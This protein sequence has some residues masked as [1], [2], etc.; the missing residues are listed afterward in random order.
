MARVR[1]KVEMRRQII[2]E[3]SSSGLGSKKFCESRGISYSTFCYWQKVERR[4]VAPISPAV[5]LFEPLRSASVN[6]SD[7]NVH[8]SCGAILQIS[9]SVP[10]SEIVSVLGSISR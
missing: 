5:I 4:S 6:G 10:L 8:F 9:S 1:T 2:A 3:F 7:Y